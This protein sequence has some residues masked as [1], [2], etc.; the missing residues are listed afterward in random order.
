[1]GANG[2]RR[3]HVNRG[4]VLISKSVHKDRIEQN[5][6]IWDFELSEE[7]MNEIAKLDIG[8]SEIVNHDDPNFVKMLHG[9]KVHK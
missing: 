6:N 5:M 7:D 1:M 4:V 3:L 8:H 2:G 9:L